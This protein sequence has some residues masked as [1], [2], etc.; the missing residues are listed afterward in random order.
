MLEWEG[1]DENGIWRAYD[2][3][4][5]YTISQ[6]DGKESCKVGYL[7][8]PGLISEWR[9]GLSSLDEAKAS[10]EH[11]VEHVHKIRSEPRR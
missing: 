1:P 2:D 7:T 5:M 4:A 9:N 11:C 10:A 8:S 3:Y 6:E